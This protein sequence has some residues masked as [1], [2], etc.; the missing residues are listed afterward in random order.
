MP[1]QKTSI[2]KE[3]GKTRAL[4]LAAQLAL[5]FF[6]M[7]VLLFLFQFA[8]HLF[9]PDLTLW[10]S[11]VVTNVVFTLLATLGAYAITRRQNR[12]LSYAVEEIK[13]RRKAEIHL[14]ELKSRI[15]AEKEKLEAVLS[16]EENLNAIFHI[17]KLIDY[18]IQTTSRVLSAKRCSLM[19]F[20]EDN[21]ELC[22]R[23]HTGIE[24][25]VFHAFKTKL[26]ESISGIVAA[27]GEPVLVEDIESDE[28]FG[29]Q[30]RSSYQWRSFMC[31]PIKIGNRLIGVINVSEKRSPE[32]DVFDK[33]DLKILCMIARQVAVAIETASLYR[34][35]NYLTITDD[36][37]GM[38]NYRHL[39]KNLDREISRLQ[40]YPG[41]LCLLLI[42][43]DNLRSYNEEFGHESGDHVL[44]ELGRVFNENIRSVD[45]SCRYSGDEFIVVLPQ[46]SI[47]KAQEVA[48]RIKAKAEE[49]PLKRKMTLSIGVAVLSGQM[50]RYDLILKADSALFKAKKKG[51]NCI[52]AEA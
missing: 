27:Q 43:V 1:Q 23:G 13:K 7:T 10:E 17:N 3:D 52:Y 32:G 46:T 9:R 14:R 42:D 49:L 33:L 25:K 12:L 2:L 15:E 24:D 45:I 18:I 8:K 41:S 38:H 16:V 44:K 34:K 48:E 29:R 39:A 50:N 37:T 36:L 11:H 51:R 5:V 47:K 20:D 31:V 26:G 21:N 30:N 4:P 28:R 40:R 6:G 19:L 35:L 22:L